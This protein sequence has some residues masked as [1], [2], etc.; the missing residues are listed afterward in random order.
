[1]ELQ[2]KPNGLGF[3]SEATL[4][5]A[6][7]QKLARGR[8]PWGKLELATEWDHKSGSVD[9]LGRTRQKSL[10]AFEAKLTEWKRAYM[11]AYR[12]AAY[13]NKVLVLMPAATVHRALA[14]A[15]E[16]ELRGIGLCSF[17]GREIRVL[18]EPKEQD[19]LLRWVRERAHT[20]FNSLRH[21]L[22]SAATASRSKSPRCRKRVLQPAGL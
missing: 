1:M 3:A 10:I 5:E 7:V 19:E 18:I 17:D 4:V 2:E 16:F 14:E 9:V 12:N 15:A 6:F 8:S 20:H 22:A 21:E 13:A 11:Q